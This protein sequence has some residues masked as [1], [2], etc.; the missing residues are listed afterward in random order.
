MSKDARD[1]I[2]YLEKA[3]REEHDDVDG[4]VIGDGAAFNIISELELLME[5]LQ[6]AEA[7]I[8]ELVAE[9]DRLQ[10]ELDAKL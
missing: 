6:E 5:K 8:A 2:A 4:V 1:L 10:D 3:R 9:R 7:F